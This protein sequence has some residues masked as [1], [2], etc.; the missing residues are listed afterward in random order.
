MH[1]GDSMWSVAE[2][3]VASR[4]GTRG[5]VDRYWMALERQNPRPDPDL[6]YP[7]QVLELPPYP[8]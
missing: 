7:G 8:E 2:A 6:I 4:G 5:Q 3:V 1:G